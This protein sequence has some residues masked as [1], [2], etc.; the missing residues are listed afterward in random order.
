MRMISRLLTFCA[1]GALATA[2][3][4]AP[5]AS[6]ADPA[7]PAPDAKQ[8]LEQARANAKA[9]AQQ[10]KYWQDL[11]RKAL[12]HERTAS[13]RLEELRA[14]WTRERH[15]QHLRGDEK[16]DLEA[17]IDKAEKDLAKAHDEVESIP[18]RARQAGAPPGWLREV[19][20]PAAAPAAN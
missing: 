17:E 18:E 8:R 2:L 20:R 16:S 19:E 13:Q 12:A 14:Q 11:Y 4:A 3:L 15:S 6:R 1:I 9:E 5:S 7:T 10:K